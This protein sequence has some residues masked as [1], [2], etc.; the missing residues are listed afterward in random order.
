[1]RRALR[2]AATVVCL[3][4]LGATSAQAYTWAS[5]SAPK[6]VS[7]NGATRGGG[8]GTVSSVAWNK[9]EL[10]SRLK[11]HRV[12]SMRTYAQTNAA[13]GTSDFLMAQSG[14]RSDGGSTYAAM[15]PKTLTASYGHGVSQYRWTTK[16]CMDRS[17]ANDPCTSPNA[18][19]QGL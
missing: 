6:L 7:Y 11:D 16:V 9:A 17:L 8:Y 4:G 13:R 2:V 12:D 18:T 1:M 10:R 15:S 14:R 19:V 3:A 5:A